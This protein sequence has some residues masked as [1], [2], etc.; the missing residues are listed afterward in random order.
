MTTETAAPAQPGAEPSAPAAELPAGTAAPTNPAP[1]GDALD[2]P[3]PAAVAEAAAKPGEV[4]TY[5]PSGDAG[6]DV[7]L[8]F[9]GSLGFGPEHAAIKAAEGGDFGLLTDALKALGDKAKGFEKILAA[10]KAGFERIDVAGKEKAS[11]TAAAIHELVG[12]QEQWSRIQAWAG[13]NATPDE[14]A[15]VNA[16]LK[17]G[18]MVAKAVARELASLYMRSPKAEKAAAP[19]RAPSA[20][21]SGA[22]STALSPEA[23]KV[24]VAKLSQKMGQR[25]DGSAEYKDLVARRRAWRG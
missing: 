17:A 8:D 23:Y 24:E 11:K 20:P 9:V 5:N 12:G 10:G 21:T 2:I 1:A 3:D 15:S 4:Y 25:M 7:A 6:L 13:E 14:R 18:G 22:V 19:A 16:A